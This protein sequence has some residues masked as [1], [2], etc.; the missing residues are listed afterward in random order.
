VKYF[1][2]FGKP[3]RKTLTGKTI[4]LGK[5]IIV[6]SAHDDSAIKKVEF[7]VHGKLMATITQEPYQWTMHKFTFGKRT[8]SVKAYDDSGK[9]STA[10]ISVT[11]FML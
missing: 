8:I 10:S 3:V 7:Y 1:H 6:A 4:L 9:V 5:T 11:A 2:L